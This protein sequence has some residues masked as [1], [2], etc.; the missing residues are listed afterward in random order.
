MMDT[1]RASADERLSAFMFIPFDR[2]PDARGKRT[3]IVADCAS[4]T[5][6]LVE[7]LAMILGS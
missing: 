7:A 1:E 3:S 4:A 2:G 5:I 6:F